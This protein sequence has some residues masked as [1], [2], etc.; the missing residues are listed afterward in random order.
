MIRLACWAV[1]CWLLASG[2]AEARFRRFHHQAQSIGT[3]NRVHVNRL[4]TEPGTLELEIGAGFGVDP[5]LLKFT[6]AGDSLWSGKTEYS[7]G[8]DYWH[9]SNDVTLAANSLLLD[10][11]RWNVSVGPTVTIVRQGTSEFSGA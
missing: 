11:E 7:V 4:I 1:G 5:A 10:G 9:G 3:R 8:F 2:V 6:G